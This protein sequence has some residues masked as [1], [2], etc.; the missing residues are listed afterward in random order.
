MYLELMGRDEGVK[1]DPLIEIKRRLS[2]FYYT[3]AQ[4]FNQSDIQ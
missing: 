2:G 4:Q 3:G 1:T